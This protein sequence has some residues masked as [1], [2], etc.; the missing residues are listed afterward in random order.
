M[1]EEEKIKRY[2]IK[3]VE[4]TSIDEDKLNGK[5]LVRNL[6]LIIDNTQPPFNI[7]ITGKSGSGKSSIINFLTAKYEKDIENYNIDKVNVWKENV[8]LKKY[9]ESKYNKVDDV[10]DIA[11]DS[12][13]IGNEIHIEQNKVN[14]ANKENNGSEYS[15]YIKKDDNQ[16]AKS[17]SLR[18]ILA[19]CNAVLT[20]VACFFITSIIF[21]I[22]E[23]LQ[24]RNIYRTNDIFFVENT[25]LNY[26]ENLGLIMLFSLV[27]TGSLLIVYNLFIKKDKRKV[28]E[29]TYK[30]Y[31]S[32]IIHNNYTM[33]NDIVTTVN[34]VEKK[35]EKKNIVI[36]ED[37]DKLSVEKMLKVL[38]EIKYCNE[39]ENC[40]FIIPLEKNILKK[41]IEVRNTIKASP[42]YKPLKFEKV[43]DKIFQFKMHMPEI[44]NSYFKEYAI[45]LVHED[46]QDFI[47]EYCEN[48]TF[49]KIIRSVLIYKNV[50][51]PRHVKKLINNFVN[52]KLLAYYKYQNG[53]LDEEFIKSKEFD[54]QLAKI[55]VLQLDFEEFYDLIFKDFSYLDKLIELYNLDKEELKVR[56]NELD[57]KLKPF[58]KVKYKPLKSFLRQTRIHKISEI[59]T[60]MYLT[61]N[62]TEKLYKGIPISNYIAGEEKISD[63][64]NK[65]ISEFIKLIDNKNDLEEFT[66]NNFEQLLENLE[67][68]IQYK[69]YFIEFNENVMEIEEYIDKQDYLKYLKLVAINYNNYP[70]EAMQVFK[71]SKVRITGD[72]MK[73]LL[74]KFEENL[75]N[76]NYQDTYEIVRDNSDCFYEENGNISS[77]V[78]F[79]VD[80][81][82]MSPNPNEIIIELDENFTRIGKIYELNRNVKGLENLD[83]DKAYKFMAKCLDNGDLYRATYVIN[84]ILS[85]ENSVEDCLNIEER[86]KK[87]NLVDIIECDVDDIIEIENSK[88]G[89]NS[90]IN[91]INMYS[92][93][94]SSID[95]T[96][97]IEKNYILLKNILEICVIKQIYLSDTDIMKLLEKALDNIEDYEYILSIY[98]IIKK[99]DRMYFY[100]SRKSFNDII[101]ASFHN[102]EN[103]DVKESAIECS[104]YFKSIRLFK[105]KLTVEEEKFYNQ[106]MGV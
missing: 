83:Y 44:T 48:E 88:L 69:D 9:L 92:Q 55:S 75:S 95:K 38:E 5:D 42:K 30:T 13:I 15:N 20:F 17:K 65:Q 63:W 7:A 54:Y 84:S 19:I 29:E 8:S 45:N 94:S 53:E 34:S 80:Y 21:V 50:T 31:D 56:Y 60:L 67:N 85:D 3:D 82:Q 70:E 25:Y 61:K 100:E 12:S 22:M 89:I 28:G 66:L 93:S 91:N 73:V 98:E 81:I 58:L 71:Y 57:E 27:L 99:L 14:S 26:S 101:Y 2:F 97:N 74:D 1:S 10:D 46:I 78:H 6:E 37:I 43:F 35:L 40:I 72:I 103:E 106:K 4:L 102:T 51:T 59:A 41:A 64:S 62:S 79:L 11:G 76:E 105:A 18:I 87:Y 86:M 47:D 39:Y 77:Y 96:E 104:R 49:E 68:N 33:Q 23:Y 16:K 52:N 36:V 24:N 32:N 90:D